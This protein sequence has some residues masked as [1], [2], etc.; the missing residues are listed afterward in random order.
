[1]NWNTQPPMNRLVGI[2]HSRSTTSA[3]AN[4][5]SEITMSGMPTVWQNRFTGCWWL[6][7]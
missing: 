6:S 4:S 3:A 1:M 2:G 5:G 7:S